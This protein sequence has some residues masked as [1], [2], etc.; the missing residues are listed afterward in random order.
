M[1]KTKDLQSAFLD[2]ARRDAGRLWRSTVL[3]GFIGGVIIAS[4]FPLVRGM[5]NLTDEAVWLLRWLLIM[6]GFSIFG[7][8]VNTVFICGIFRSGGESRFGLIVDSAMMWL[9]S[10]PLGFLCAFVLHVPPVLVYIIMFLDE[11][12]KMPFI[13]RYY[14]SGK[15]LKNITRE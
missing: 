15:W 9:V 6:N 10:V 12:E 13:I 7:A 14:R 5:K 1:Q 11:Y 2:R 3:A 8:S 4:S